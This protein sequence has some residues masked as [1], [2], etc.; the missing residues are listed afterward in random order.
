MTGN[1]QDDTL[2]DVFSK[3]YYMNDRLKIRRTTELSDTDMQVQ[4][5]IYSDDVIKIT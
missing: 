4:T 5:E 3:Y 2:Q 1:K